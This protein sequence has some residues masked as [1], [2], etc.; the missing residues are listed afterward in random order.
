[1]YRNLLQKQFF[2]YIPVAVAYPET[3][4]TFVTGRLQQIRFTAVY[5]LFPV[6]TSFY[7]F[8]SYIF[9]TIIYLRR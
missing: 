7:G 9:Q 1:M 3:G 2:A 4:I 6:C 5:S 8:V